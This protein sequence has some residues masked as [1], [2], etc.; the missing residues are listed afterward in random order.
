MKEYRAHGAISQSELKLLL[1][2]VPSLLQTV[3]NPD[4]YFEEKQHFI[5]GDAVDCQLTRGLEEFNSSFYVSNLENKPSDKIK[6]IVNQVFDHVKEVYN[7]IGLITE[8]ADAILDA[9]NDHEYQT[10][11]GDQLRINKITEAWEYWESLKDAQ[12]KIV[13]SQEDESLINSIIMSFRTHPHTKDYFTARDGVEIHY[14]LPIFFTHKDIECKSLLDMVIVNHNDKTIQPIDIKTMGDKNVYFSKSMRQRRY[15]IQAAFYTLAIQHW[16]KEQGLGEYRLLAFKFLVESTVNP[17]MPLVYKCTSELL[18]MGR[19]GRE[20]GNLYLKVPN[21]AETWEDRLFTTY[22]EIKGFEQLIDD[23]K[24]YL[25]HDFEM[26]R[27]VRE[28]KGEL[29]LDWNN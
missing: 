19:W 16:M 15:D 6:S 3:E 14:Q 23:Y 20:E 17:G 12:G 25:E 13:L 21:S 11:W 28:S 26:S 9:C 24:Y 5:I 1:G 4:L 29:E 10:R 27:L 7:P 18:Y 22:Q 2:P 8:Y